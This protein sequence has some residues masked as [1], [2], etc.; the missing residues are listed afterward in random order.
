MKTKIIILV[1]LLASL[2][3]TVMTVVANEVIELSRWVLSG[4]IGDSTAEGITLR[5]T[6]GQPVV[7]AISNGDITIGQSFWYGE[8]QIKVFL[9]LVQR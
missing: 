9:P 1:L 6:L 3:I 8:I 2:L 5:T 4:G 7:G